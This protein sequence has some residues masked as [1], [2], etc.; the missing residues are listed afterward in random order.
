G[1]SP[2]APARTGARRSREFGGYEPT[3]AP[4]ARIR[5]PPRRSRSF[6][7]SG[8]TGQESTPRTPH[9]ARSRVNRSLAASGLL[10]L[11]RGN[12]RSLAALG[13]VRGNQVLLQLEHH[14]GPPHGEGG[15]EEE[16]RQ[17]HDQEHQADQPEAE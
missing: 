7:M 1:R 3:K 16:V 2:R 13:A 5:A 9:V 12:S 15:G 8:G 11:V 10:R 4:P 6:S 14:Q 17:R